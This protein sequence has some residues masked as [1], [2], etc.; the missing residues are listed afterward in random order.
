[1]Q[2]LTRIFV[3]LLLVV[4]ITFGG[5]YSNANAA[6]VSGNLSIQGT[7]SNAIV[8]SPPSVGGGVIR[9]NGSN[10]S[11]VSFG[12]K[13]G[14][15]GTNDF[16]VAFWLQTTEKYRYF[17]LA[18]NRTAGSHG[19]FLAIRQTGKHE[20]IPEGIV[21]AEVDQDQNG[22]NYIGIQSQA[23]GLNDGNWHHIVVGRKGT[24]LKLYVDG[25]LSGCGSG[26]G[27]ANIN[28]GNPFKLGR[29][30][31]GVS[32]KFAADARYYEF[33]VYDFALND[34]EVLSLFYSAGL[35]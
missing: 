14:Q 29:S 8:E 20:S 7:L 32:D 30:L 6:V 34:D 5:F 11:F 15:F 3:A 2:S 28:N 10:D 9:I 16:T 25:V 1:M 18:G 13:I 33:R 24:S 26:K 21:S 12:T 27:V 4:G 23:K 31:V 35:R 19:N 17:D 22:T